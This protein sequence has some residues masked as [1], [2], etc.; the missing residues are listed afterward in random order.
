[1]NLKNICFF[2]FITT[3]NL[4]SQQDKL[5]VEI[6]DKRSGYVLIGKIR[7]IIGKNAQIDHPLAGAN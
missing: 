7:G 4:F 6:N 3:F 2:L 1:M 5:S